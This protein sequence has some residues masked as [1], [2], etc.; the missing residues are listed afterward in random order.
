MLYPEKDEKN[1]FD[2]FFCKLGSKYYD[3]IH[4]SNAWIYGRVRC[5]LAHEYSIRTKA[6][7]ESMIVIEG[8][9]C[10]IVYNKRPEITLFM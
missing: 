6:D 1:S 4:N 5:G 8:W 3:L 7:S 2:V 9:D 10:G